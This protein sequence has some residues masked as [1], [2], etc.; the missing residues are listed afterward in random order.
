MVEVRLMTRPILLMILVLAQG[1]PK[2]IRLIFGK[3]NEL[4]KA[5]TEL[6]QRIE[7]V[8]WPQDP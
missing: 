3:R 2:Y 5:K 4:D 1:M 7:P 6:G 8:L